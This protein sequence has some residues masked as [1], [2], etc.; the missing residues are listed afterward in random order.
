[1]WRTLGHELLIPSEPTLFWRIVAEHK[2][3]HL[4]RE[5]YVTTLTEAVKSPSLFKK[6]ETLNG[7]CWK[8]MILQWLP[9]PEKVPRFPPPITEPHLPELSRSGIKTN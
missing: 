5:Y 9:N 4:Q 3:K 6:S 1:M 2:Q 7:Y 8:W